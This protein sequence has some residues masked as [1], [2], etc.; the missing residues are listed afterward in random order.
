MKKIKVGFIGCGRIS[1]LHHLGY[2]DHPSAQVYA[3]CDTDPEVLKRRT[4]E[5]HT[6]KA[7]TDYREMLQDPD[8]DAVEI[9]SPH[10]YHEEMAVAAA[11]AGKHMVVQKPMTVDMESAHRM[12]QAAEKAGVVFQVSDNYMFY[13]P[14]VLVK[15]MIDQGEIGAPMSIRIKMIGAG[16]GGWKVPDS[17][18]EWRIV[19]SARGMGLETFDHGHHLWA[20]AWYLMGDVERVVSWIDTLDGIVDSP[21]VMMW[22]YKDGV[23]YGSCDFSFGS[24]M[25]VPSKYYSNDE[26]IEVA[27]TKGLVVINR[28]TGNIKDGPGVSRFDGHRWHHYSDVETDWSE[29]FIGASRNFI[30]AM[31]GKSEPLL[32]GEQG[33]EIL[34]FNLAVSKSSRERREVY[35]DEMEAPS[36]EEYT[37]DRIRQEKAQ[38]EEKRRQFLDD[39]MKNS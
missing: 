3:V 25:H 30:Q 34:K 39:I 33:K 9:L 27:G 37:R 8:L 17:A 26:W 2:V 18:W 7:Y 28:C 36:P 13:P 38:A 31:Q 22:K 24:E 35:L 29:G 20:T 19:E 4:K 21:A 10:P 11:E 12:T 23:K 32:S 5:W 16:S 14:I 15:K 6:H 1:D